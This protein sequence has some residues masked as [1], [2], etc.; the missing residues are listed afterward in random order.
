MQKANGSF[1][2]ERG[3]GDYETMQFNNEELKDKWFQ[4]A[5]T[6]LAGQLESDASGARDGAKVRTLAGAVRELAGAR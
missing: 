1:A 4:A 5:L 2:E 6:A 3:L